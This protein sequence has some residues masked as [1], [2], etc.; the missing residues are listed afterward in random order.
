MD[1]TLVA[2]K[3]GMSNIVTWVHIVETAENS[4]FLDGGQLVFTTGIGLNSTAGIV[5][6]LKAFENKNVAGV[7]FNI[8]PFIDEIPQEAKQYGDEHNLPIFTVPWRVHLAEIMRICCYALTKEEQRTME[9]SAA[10]KNAISFPKQEELYVVSLSQRSFQANWKYSAAVMQLNGTAEDAEERIENL[11]IQLESKFHAD[12]KKTVFFA[13]GAELVAVFANLDQEELLIKAR[14]IRTSV[15]MF[16]KK[17]ETVSI[18]VGR[19][20]QSIRCLY[21]SYNQAK[22]IERLQ[23]GGKIDSD[24]IFYTNLGIYRLLMGIE[25]KEIMTEYYNQTIKPIVDYDEANE[26]DLCATLRCYLKHDGSVKETAEE[27]FV[28]RNTI[29]Y[30]LNKIEELLGVDMS[31]LSARSQLLIAFSL[32]DIMC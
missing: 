15:K 19:L 26:S 9:I 23:A 1:I 7:I 3:G 31:S 30:K 5:D 21:K 2:G 6:L 25:D 10:F 18:G 17:E 22:S 11:C 14:E 24:E 8:G 28:H 13:N 16:L 12:S 20:T 4:D 32:Q 29:N 27:L